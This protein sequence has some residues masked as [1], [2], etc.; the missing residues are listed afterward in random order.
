MIR[1]TL[2]PVLLAFLVP[3][4]AWSANPEPAVAGWIPLDSV[5]A[6]QIPT[7]VHPKSAEQRG[8]QRSV[9]AAVYINASP[10]RLWDLMRDCDQA[11][12]F[13]PGL[14]RCEVLETAP[15]GSS[16]Q[17]EHEIKYAWFIP[18]VT[19]RFRADYVPLRSIRFKRVSGGLRQL[20]GSW[21][22]IELSQ[23]GTLVS[24]EVRIVPGFMVP[25]WAV[26]RSVKKQLPRVLKALRERAEAHPS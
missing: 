4:G 5:L 3:S 9:S 20:E 17:I 18:R 11:P 24:Y 21:Q 10:A 7:Y 15:D 6:G 1:A 23:G 2:S 12:E 13:V 19:Y 22:L 14:K 25:K 16:Q 26:R 8:E